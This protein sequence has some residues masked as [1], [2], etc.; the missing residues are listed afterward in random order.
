MESNGRGADGIDIAF[1]NGNTDD[2]GVFGGS[3]GIGGLNNATGFKLDT[4]K[5]DNNLAALMMSASTGWAKNL[6]MF[7]ID[8]FDYIGSENAYI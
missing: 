1:H 8:S 3:N 7:K 4:S 6:H 5:Y 2:L